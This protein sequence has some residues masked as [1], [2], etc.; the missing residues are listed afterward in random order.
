MLF[1]S[2]EHIFDLVQPLLQLS[3]ALVRGGWW[4][5]LIGKISPVWFQWVQIVI[6][7]SELRWV[8]MWVQTACRVV[9]SLLS[10]SERLQRLSACYLR[11]VKISHQLVTVGREPGATISIAEVWLNILNAIFS[12]ALWIWVIL[13]VVSGRLYHN[14]LVLII[15]GQWDQVWIV[16]DYSTSTYVKASSFVFLFGLLHWEIMNRSKSS[17]AQSVLIRTDLKEGISW[18]QKLLLLHS[19]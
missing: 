11:C 3:A 2:A 5:A 6:I 19:N 15:W 14:P 10:L 16:I 12:I 9:I 17:S 1:K 13:R 7:F 18:S 8:R 4:A